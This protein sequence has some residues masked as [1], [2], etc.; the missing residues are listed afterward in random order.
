MIEI[1]AAIL[2][3]V[4]A[5]IATLKMRATWLIGIASCLLYMIVFQRAELWGMFALQILMVFQS[6][7][8]FVK[9]KSLKI[10]ELSH[11]KLLRSAL[12]FTVLFVPI[13]IMLYF[14]KFSWLELAVCWLSVLATWMLVT[15]DPRNW[16]VWSLTNLVSVGLFVNDKLYVSAVTFFLLLIN[17]IYASWKWHKRNGSTASF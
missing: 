13:G 6:L 12:V 17:S 2:T 10:Q 8:G 5:V 7:S 14:E 16:H 9:W 15:G 3:I 11:S 1:A 4:S